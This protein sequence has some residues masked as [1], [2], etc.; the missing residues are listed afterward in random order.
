MVD[1]VMVVSI[2]VASSTYRVTVPKNTN[3]YVAM[4]ILASSTTLFRFKATL[5]SELGYYIEEINGI[6][7]DNGKYWT[8]YVN[9]SYSNVGVS[10]YIL[11]PEDQIEWKLK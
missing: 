11:K 4:T 10:R 3:I 8:L 9:D 1:G 7:N 6:K 2:G 5:Y